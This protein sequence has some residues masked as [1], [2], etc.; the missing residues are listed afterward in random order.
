M[1]PPP[2][3]AGVATIPSREATFREML[4]TVTTQVDQ[5]HVYLSGHVGYLKGLPKNCHQ[6]K[7]PPFSG[8]IE[9]DP[10]GD[11][12]KFIGLRDAQDRQGYYL[13]FDDDLYYPPE[14]ASTLIRA[15]ERYKRKALVSFHGRSFGRF[16]IGNYYR[17]ATQRYY[18]LREV[19]KDVAVQVP[20]S[21]CAGFHTDTIKMSME[22]FPSRSMADV[23]LAVALRRVRVPAIC[24]QHR[25]NWIKHL[26]IDHGSSLYNQHK[27]D[28]AEQTAR[29]NEAF[30]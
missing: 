19:K 2:I 3:I 14:Y 20:G 25:A 28:C 15:I 29:I 10:W 27:D 26:P 1:T 22:D 13:T 30:G 18:C 17:D 11:A 12:G 9:G 5:L 7:P 23:H 4:R 16:P 21:G 24:L 6:H 8:G